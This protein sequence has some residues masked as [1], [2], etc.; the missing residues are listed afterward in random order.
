MEKP[1]K[2]YCLDCDSNHPEC[3]CFGYNQAID[4]YEKWLN[5]QAYF[6][7][8]DGD[9]YVMVTDKTKPKEKTKC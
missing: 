6:Q 7:D 8:D 9:I 2:K 3:E 4:D 1:K 5:E